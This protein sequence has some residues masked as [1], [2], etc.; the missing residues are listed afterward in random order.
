MT[1][2]KVD[3]DYVLAKFVEVLDSDASWSTKVRALELMGKYLGMFIEQKKVN[4][5][6]KSLVS[7][8]GVADLQRIADGNILELTR[9]VRKEIGGGGECYS[10]TSDSGGVD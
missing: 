5:D 1:P 10:I 9:E 6:I 3:V 2:S 7:T 4:I 8:L